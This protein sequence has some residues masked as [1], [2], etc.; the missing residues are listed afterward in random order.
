MKHCALCYDSCLLIQ[1]VPHHCCSPEKVIRSHEIIGSIYQTSHTPVETPV[2][3]WVRSLFQ[4]I[5]LVYKKGSSKMK[6]H[7]R[8]IM[9]K[10]KKKSQPYKTEIKKNDSKYTNIFPAALE[11]GSWE[12]NRKFFLDECWWAVCSRRKTLSSLS[13]LYPHPKKLCLL[14][15]DFIKEVVNCLYY[16]LCFLPRNWIWISLPCWEGRLTSRNVHPDKY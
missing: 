9:W 13:W 6:H 5:L 10:K 1:F 7:L 16:L 14:K 2:R 4:I 8:P 3:N 12:K 15:S 11:I